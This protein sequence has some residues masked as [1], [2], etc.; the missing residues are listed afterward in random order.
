MLRDGSLLAVLRTECAETG[1]MYRTRSA[2]GGK[3]WEETEEL[4]PFGVLPQLLTLE[5]GVTVLAFGRPGVHLLFSKDGR[6]KE[7]TI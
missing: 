4:Y 6:G 7:S 2:D 3:T 1:P 5:N